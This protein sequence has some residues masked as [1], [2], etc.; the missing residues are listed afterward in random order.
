MN[1]LKFAGN[2]LGYTH[3]EEALEKLRRPKSAESKALM[4]EV[5]LGENNPNFGKIFSAET[6]ALMSEAHK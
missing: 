2:S 5:K 4:S 3:T 6:K 1:I